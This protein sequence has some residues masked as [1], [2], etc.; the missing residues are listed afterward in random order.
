MLHKIVISKRAYN[1]FQSIC[2]YLVDEFGERVA[3]NFEF[4]V[5]QCVSTLI[6]FPE[7]GHPEPIATIPLT[8]FGSDLFGGM[9]DSS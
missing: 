2:D 4:E 8:I 6:K 1:Q 9:V 5:E 3:D 7:A